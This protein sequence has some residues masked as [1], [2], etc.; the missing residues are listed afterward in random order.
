VYLGVVEKLLENAHLEDQEEDRKI[1][2]RWMSRKQIVRMRCG[3][4]LKC[5][6]KVVPAL[7]T[8]H[9]GHTGGVEV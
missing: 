4:D 8:D 7:L 6:N 1:I 3:C 2:L 5:K 9:H